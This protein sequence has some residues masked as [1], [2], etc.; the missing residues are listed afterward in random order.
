MI[1]V[2]YVL[3]RHALHWPGVLILQGPFAQ[4]SKCYYYASWAS[5]VE[6]LS[7]WNLN[8]LPTWELWVN[9]S[10]P[11]RVAAFVSGSFYGSIFSRTELPNVHV[12]QSKIFFLLFRAALMGYRVSQSRDW[13]RAITASLLHARTMQ[14]PNHIWDLAGSVPQWVRPGIEPTSS[15]ILVEFLTCWASTGTPKVRF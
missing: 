8:H 15:W 12:F 1:C 14:D 6:I 4:N 11:W 10:A 9:P 5:H 13:N 7:I 3:N 2:S